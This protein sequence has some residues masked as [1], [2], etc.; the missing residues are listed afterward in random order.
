[1]LK[2]GR[3]IEDLFQLGQTIE[4]FLLPDDH[5]HIALFDN[6]IEGRR[7]VEHFLTNHLA[8]HHA[9]DL[10]LYPDHVDVVVFANLGL[11]QPESREMVGHC[12]FLDAIAGNQLK[13][14]EDIGGYQPLCQTGRGIAFGKDHFGDPEI[15]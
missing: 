1:M 10:L 8:F 11:A 3:K 6:V 7:H 5:Q 4:V 2:I 14:F 12:D 13:V 9:R 15:F